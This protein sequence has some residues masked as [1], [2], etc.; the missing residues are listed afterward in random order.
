MVSLDPVG[1]PSPPT[2][3]AASLLGSATRYGRGSTG[4][5]QACF[6]GISLGYHGERLCTST[7]CLVKMDNGN[8]LTIF[9]S[10]QEIDQQQ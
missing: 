2:F 1:P 3:L 10:L 8:T 6:I 5:H 4:L 7:F 9:R